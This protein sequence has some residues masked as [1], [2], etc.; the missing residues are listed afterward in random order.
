MKPPLGDLICKLLISHKH[1]N[2]TNKFNVVNKSIDF[3]DKLNNTKTTLQKIK[4]KFK[5]QHD[6]QY[7][8]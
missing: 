6:C 1:R 5:V 2:L 3:S 4:N 8:C 7:A